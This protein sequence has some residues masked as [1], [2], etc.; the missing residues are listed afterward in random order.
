[1]TEWIYCP[2]CAARLEPKPNNEGVERPTCPN[3]HYIHYENPTPAAGVFVEHQGKY[4]I[5]KRGYAPKK[6][7]WD[8]PGGYIE[9]TEQPE[10]AVRRELTEETG[11]QVTDVKILTSHNSAFGD[12]P[13]EVKQN[14]LGIYYTCR[15]GSDVVKL[16]PENP[17]YR[18]V[19]PDEFPEMASEA[20]RHAIALLR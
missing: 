18:W 14:V 11:L 6:G 20:D 12:G 16:S 17:E 10:D 7:Y 4:L 13:D 9:A 19:A 2:E 1:M 5:V 3:G 8:L 15:A